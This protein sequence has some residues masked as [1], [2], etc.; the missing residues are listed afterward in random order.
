MSSAVSEEW[1]PRAVL[2]VADIDRTL[3]FYV[4]R[5]GFTKQWHFGV[6]G[7]PDVAQ[8]DRQGCALIFSTES[9]DKAGKGLIFISLNVVTPE[10][11]IHAEIE[12]VDRLRVEF[13][14]RGVNVD[15]G[16]W[17]HRVLIVHDP[18]GNELYFPYPDVKEEAP[19]GAEAE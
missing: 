10:D 11:Q 15:E 16:F 13:E 12:A 8:A 3:D 19:S 4:N 14:G 9:P 17:G 2:F 18:D 7:T 5:L 6:E 1:Y